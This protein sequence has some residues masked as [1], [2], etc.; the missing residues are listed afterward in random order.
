MSGQDLSYWNFLHD[1]SRVLQYEQLWLARTKLSNA[2]GK[3]S[4]QR[5]VIYSWVINLLCA[6]DGIN[7]WFSHKIVTSF[8]NYLRELVIG[9]Y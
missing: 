9:S 8:P 4:I 7:I 2:A 3:F 1:F 6:L 5:T